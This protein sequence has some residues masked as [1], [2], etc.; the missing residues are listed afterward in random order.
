MKKF[1]ILVLVLCLAALPA[2]AEADAVSSASVI[3]LSPQ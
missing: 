3:S 2:L 1:F